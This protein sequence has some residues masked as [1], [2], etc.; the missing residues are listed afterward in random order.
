[1]ARDWFSIWMGFL[2]YLIAQTVNYANDPEDNA[3]LHC[4]YR[5]L[6]DRGFSDAWLS[7]LMGSTVNSF[8]AATPVPELLCIWFVWSKREEEAVARDCELTYLRPP[9][10]VLQRALQ[11]I[12]HSPSFPLAML[13]IKHYYNL[14]LGNPVNDDTL[15]VLSLDLA[16]SFVI[17][18]VTSQFLKEDE[19]CSHDA[20]S[21]SLFLKEFL[22]RH[23][24]ETHRSAEEAAALPSQGMVERTNPD[25]RIF[26]H[27]SDYFSR[28]DKLQKEL[29]TVQTPEERQR[30]ASYE[31]NPPTKNTKMYTWERVN[32]SGGIKVYVRVHVKKSNHQNTLACYEDFKTQYNPFFNEWDFCTDYLGSPVLK[33]YDPGDDSDDDYDY[34]GNNNSQPQYTAQNNAQSSPPES[35]PLIPIAESDRL[36]DNYTPDDDYHETPQT[37]VLENLSRLYGYMIS[38]GSFF[39]PNQKYR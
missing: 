28:Q 29:E 13:V 20:N 21:T 22:K 2:S 32:S 23:N 27:W 24:T 1:M 8:D 15:K 3:G 34:D 10:E 6:L 19:L 39:V 5:L 9:N 25:D 33:G 30:R 4:W 26:N 31:C 16:P 11:R 37:D 36:G 12:F 38:L 7:G 17:E 35:L 14:T 18:F